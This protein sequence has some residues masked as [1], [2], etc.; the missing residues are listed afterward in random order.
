MTTARYFCE[1]VLPKVHSLT[2]AVTAGH[3]ILY[4]IDA[5]ALA[6]S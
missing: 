2:P 4:E 3:S 5:E 1:Q 6:S